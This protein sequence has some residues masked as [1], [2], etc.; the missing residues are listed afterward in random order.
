MICGVSGGSFAALCLL[1][2]CI[3]RRRRKQR[4]PMRQPLLSAGQVQPA[5]GASAS[6]ARV[7]PVATLVVTPIDA[8]VAVPVATP[9]AAS[10]SAA[11]ASTAGAPSLPTASSTRASDRMP[12]EGSAITPSAF[13]DSGSASFFF[14]DGEWGSERWVPVLDSNAT[15]A[16]TACY[17]GKT[18]AACQYTARSQEYE[19]TLGS[20]GMLLQTNTITNKRRRVKKADQAVRSSGNLSLFDPPRNW[21]VGEEGSI[22]LP[23]DSSEYKDVEKYFRARLRNRNATIERI[24]RIQSLEQW[25]G[26]KAK[27]QGLAVRE[28]SRREV[29]RPAL[30][31]RAALEKAWLFHGCSEET[32][33][34]I[35]ARGFNRSYAGAN[36]TLYGKGTYFARDAEY[37]ARDQYSAP[38][39]NGQKHIFLCRVAVGAAAKVPSGYNE[40]VPPVRD[41][42]LLYDATANKESEPDIVV[43]FKDNQAYPEYRVIFCK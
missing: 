23:S 32:A 37:S 41:G 38:S 22:R 14:E 30:P 18:G 39:T 42:D 21:L 7:A 27:L 9:V 11:N 26:Y 4:R 8:P 2:C 1:G 34:L 15:N 6:H 12:T 35:I 28:T 20:D 31:S 25:V 3:C 36:A 29:G 16:Y 5:Q 33:K 43:V 19:V 17:S 13:L 40:V 10:S 24:E